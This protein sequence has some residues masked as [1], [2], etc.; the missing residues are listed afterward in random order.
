MAGKSSIAEASAEAIADK[1]DPALAPT[2]GGAYAFTLDNNE[3][4]ERYLISNAE[5]SQLDKGAVRAFNK[6]ANRVEKAMDCIDSPVGYKERYDGKTVEF[7]G[8]EIDN[9]NY[10]AVGLSLAL[11]Q[12]RFDAVLEKAN[13]SEYPAIDPR[14]RYAIDRM[15]AYYQYIERQVNFWDQW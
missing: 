12:G 15:T 8:G 10:I 5:A 9:N 3:N 4:A 6:F 7:H 2:G 1:L 13:E 14:W 11:C